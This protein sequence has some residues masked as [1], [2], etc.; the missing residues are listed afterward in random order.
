MDASNSRS[1]RDAAEVVSGT[2]GS[3]ATDSGSVEVCA[4]LFDILFKPNCSP[5]VEKVD[6]KKSRF[7]ALSSKVNI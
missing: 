6:D 5:V 7:N 2:H 1:L 4:A 3:T